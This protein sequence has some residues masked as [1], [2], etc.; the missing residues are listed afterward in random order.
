MDP[1]KQAAELVGALERQARVLRQ[2][3][4]EHAA[5]LEQ[6][7]RGAPPGTRAILDRARRSFERLLGRLRSDFSANERAT[8]ELTFKHFLD[9]MAREG[10]NFYLEPRLRAELYR[11]QQDGLYDLALRKLVTDLDA[12]VSRELVSALGHGVKQEAAARKASAAAQQMAE[13]RVETVSRTEMSYSY[14][15]AYQRALEVA[16]ETEDETKDPL[17]KRIEEYFD[18]KNHPFSRVAHGTI[19]PVNKPF[20]VSVASVSAMGGLMR[21]SSGGVFW[22]QTGANYQGMFLPAHYND[23]GRIV[24]HRRS[25]GE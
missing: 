14:N 5:A 8:Q 25:W 21:K 10:N 20:S 19:A 15:S 3:M 17:M 2:S 18:A 6:E 22:P 7:I 4:T 24:A 12:R 16:S 23:R 11:L 9:T 1:V 13:Q